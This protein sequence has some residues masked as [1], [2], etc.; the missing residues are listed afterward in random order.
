[1]ERIPESI[2]SGS[3]KL[4]GV[5]VKCHTLDNGERIIEADSVHDLIEAMELGFVPDAEQ[6]AEFA[7][8]RSGKP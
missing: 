3:F 2:W 1:M 8:W 6:L 7:R 4:F 5:D